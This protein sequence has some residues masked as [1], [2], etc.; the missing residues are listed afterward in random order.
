MNLNQPNGEWSQVSNPQELERSLDKLDIFRDG[1]IKEAH[2]VNS[3]SASSELSLSPE[4]L[5]VVKLLVE[6]NAE[7]PS[8]VEMIFEEVW[9]LRLQ[10]AS[11][12]GNL[13]DRCGLVG[14]DRRKPANALVLE[15]AGSDIVFERM[16]W[17]LSAD[18]IGSSS[19]GQVADQPDD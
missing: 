14:S 13:Q 15:L 3:E 10:P 17:R 6:S 7:V 16:K 4:N 12:T 9:R 8:K 11:F 18:S 19:S 5:T 1:V 2:W